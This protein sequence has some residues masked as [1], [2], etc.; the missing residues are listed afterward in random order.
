MAD[1]QRRR[2][3]TAREVRVPGC[4]NIVML[5]HLFGKKTSRPTSLSPDAPTV[6]AQ[7]QKREGI[8]DVLYADWNAILNGGRK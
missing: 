6:A 2:E 3:I 4:D 5:F 7:S 8:R 1:G